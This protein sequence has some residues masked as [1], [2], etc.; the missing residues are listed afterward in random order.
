MDFDKDR[1]ENGWR[2]TLSADEVMV[3]EHIC[4]ASM[5]QFGYQFTCEINSD[6]SVRAILENIDADLLRYFQLWKR[7][8]G[9]QKFPTDP[10]D[11]R[12][13]QA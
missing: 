5:E 8:K 9:I 7:G 10:L 12:N 13:W 3:V 11:K 4:R 1:A 2:N 6:R